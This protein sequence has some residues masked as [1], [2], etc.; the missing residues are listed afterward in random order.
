MMDSTSSFS[1]VG[2]ESVMHRT[3]AVFLPGILM[4][5]TLRYAPLR[6]ELGDVRPTLTKELAVYD[7]PEPPA[8]YSVGF[9]LDA[10]DAFADSH[11]LDRFHLYGHSAGAA[12]ALAYTARHR[13]RVMSLALDEPAS[14]FSDDDLRAIAADLPDDLAELPVPERMEVFARSLV[15]DGV[16]V[17]LPIPSAAPEMAARPAGVVAFSGALRSH[18]LDRG[19]LSAFDGPVYFSYGSLSNARWEAMASRLEQ[20]LRHC[21]VERYEGLHHLNTSHTTEPA[22]VALALQRLWSDSEALSE[23]RG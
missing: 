16:Q 10:L 8:R 7:G 6:A 14:D 9:E 20:E 22:R 13:D 18:D 12:I 5:A 21:T 3:A 19:A 11:E 2:T 17:Q 1:A 23:P 15:R 4:P